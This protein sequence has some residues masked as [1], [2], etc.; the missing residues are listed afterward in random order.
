MNLSAPIF[1][2]K[3]RAK[4]ISRERRVPL[5]EALNSVA[6]GEGFRSWSL[7]AAHFAKVDPASAML[8]TLEPGDMVLVGARPM[9]GKTALVLNI[10]AE[11]RKAGSFCAL[12][13]LEYTQVEASELLK[14]HGLDMESEEV[15]LDS[16][17]A[18]CA[19]YIIA[20]LAGVKAGSVV[21]I[22][23]LQALDHRR[24]TPPLADQ[25]SALKAFARKAGLIFIVISQ[26]DRHYDAATKAVPDLSDVR[27]PNTFDTSLFNKSC[28][29]RDGQISFSAGN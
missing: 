12:F 4:S 28:F 11:A 24:E 8:A 26:I 1:Q 22:D 20:K 16:S 13:T 18:I 9:H 3:R 25:I 19:E 6:E 7:L 10:L 27:M 14:S 21:G 17:D 5:F 15:Y 29:M 2:L 23:Y